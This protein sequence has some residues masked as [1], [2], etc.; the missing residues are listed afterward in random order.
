MIFFMNRLSSN[1]QSL[2]KKLLGW[3]SPQ[4]QS[5]QLQPVRPKNVELK[6]ETFPDLQYLE[7][8]ELLSGNIVTE[9]SVTP[10]TKQV[11]NQTVSNNEKYT[12][13]QILASF[14]P[15]SN[16]TLSLALQDSLKTQYALLE[17]VTEKNR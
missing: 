11:P 10:M 3:V 12:L 4:K 7:R 16:S 15:K 6:T 17:D 14:H 5:I 9:S 8:L 13:D 1:I 2:L